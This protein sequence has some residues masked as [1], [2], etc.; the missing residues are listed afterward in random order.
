[1]KD[2]PDRIHA[3]AADAVGQMPGNRDPE[4]SEDGLGEDGHQYKIALSAE[5]RRGVSEDEGADDIARRLLRHPQQRSQ[6]DLLWLTFEHFQDR[7]AFDALF[8]EHLLEDR[9]LGDAEADPQ[10]DSDHHNAEKER[11]PPSPNEEL[12]TGP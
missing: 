2:R 7:H 11:N 12:T 5:H 8:V 1:D 9:G 10:T 4:E 3:L 6:R